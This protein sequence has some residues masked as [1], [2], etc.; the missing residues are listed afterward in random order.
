MAK[1][2]AIFVSTCE[3]KMQAEAESKN[4]IIRIYEDK[5]LY[6]RNDAGN[7]AIG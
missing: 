4:Q 3:V 5:A 1:V 6:Y 2:C 7:S